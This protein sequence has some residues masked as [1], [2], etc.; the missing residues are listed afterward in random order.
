[1]DRIFRKRTVSGSRLGRNKTAKNKTPPVAPLPQLPPSLD[2]DIRSSLI[3]PGLTERFSVLLPSLAAAP[4]TSVR[5]LLAQQRNRPN[6]PSLTLEE[7]EMLFAEMQGQSTAGGHGLHAPR[8]TESRASALTTDTW[9]GNPPPLEGDWGSLV[10]RGAGAISG[11]LS[12]PT[13]RE[14]S[15]SR[16]G[17][18]PS[19][20]DRQLSPSTSDRSLGSPPHSASYSS[21]NTFGPDEGRPVP[22]SYGFSGSQGWRDANYLRSVKKSANASKTSVATNGHGEYNPEASTSPRQ[23]PSTWSTSPKATTPKRKP[24]PEVF[25]LNDSTEDLHE[26]RDISQSPSSSTRTVTPTASVTGSVVP[27]P[28]RSAPTRAS[29]DEPQYTTTP[30]STDS[31]FSKPRPRVQQVGGAPQQRQSLLVGITPQQAKRISLALLEIEGHLGRDAGHSS[32]SSHD[33]NRHDDHEELLEGYEDEAEEGEQTVTLDRQRSFTSTSAASSV[34]PFSVSPASS[35]HGGAGSYQGSMAPRSPAGEPTSP[36]NVPSLPSSPQTTKDPHLDQHTPPPHNRHASPNRQRHY[37]SASIASTAFSG[38]D[39]DDGHLPHP[40]LTPYRPQPVRATPSPAFGMS[41]GGS[42]YVPGQPRPV[43]SVSSAGSTPTVGSPQSPYSP[44]QTTELP[45]RLQY[46]SPGSSATTLPQ[47]QTRTS[48][49]RAPSA[50]T[51]YSNGSVSKIDHVPAPGV[52]ASRHATGHSISE[53]LSHWRSGSALNIHSPPMSRVLS[54]ADEARSS[55]ASADSHRSSTAPTHSRSHSADPGFRS[56]LVTAGV[57]AGG[58]GAA[59]AGAASL[60]HARGPSLGLAPNRSLRRAASYDS[61]SSDYKITPTDEAKSG[62]E[63]IVHEHHQSQENLLLLSTGEEEHD[64]EYL[65]QVSGVGKDDLFAMQD[66]LMERAKAERERQRALHALPASPEVGVAQPPSVASPPAAISRALETEVPQQQDYVQSVPFPAQGSQVSLI[67]ATPATS[68]PFPKTPSQTTLVAANK[69]SPPRERGPPTAWKTAG[70]APVNAAAASSSTVHLPVDTVAS[71][72][73]PLDPKFPTEHVPASE[74]PKGP[75]PPRPQHPAEAPVLPVTP[76]TPDAVATKADEEE[77]ARHDVEMRIKQAN[78]E[79]FR[80]PSRIAHKRSLSKKKISTPTLVSTSHNQ[81]TTPITPAKTEDKERH[82]G[83]KMSMRW[84]KLVHKKSSISGADS[85]QTAPPVVATPPSNHKKTKSPDIHPTTP[86]SPKAAKQP[87]PPVPPM[88]KSPPEPV[89]PNPTPRSDINSFKFPYSGPANGVN[90]TH[91][92]KTNGRADMGAQPPWGAQSKAQSPPLKSSLKVTNNDAPRGAHTPTA[93]DSSVAES[94]HKFMEAGRA[95]GLDDDRLNDVLVQN[96]ILDRTATSN[97]SRSYQSTAPTTTTFSESSRSPVSPTVPTNAFS[98]WAPSKKGQHKAKAPSRDDLH[99]VPEVIVQ[100]EPGVLRRTLVVPSDS[101]R[102]PEPQ[103]TPNANHQALPPSPQ[104]A[105]YSLKGPSSPGQ[106]TGSF[107]SVGRQNSI[108]RKPVQRSGVEERELVNRSPVSSL[109]TRDRKVSSFSV[110]DSEVSE[111]LAPPSRQWNG[112][113]DSP[114]RQFFGG[115]DSA[116]AS[117]DSSRGGGSIYDYYGGN[118]G[119]DRGSQAVEITEYAD[120]RVVWNIVN[121]LRGDRGSTAEQS[122]HDNQRESLVS[123]SRQSSE[124]NERDS[125]AQYGETTGWSVG[126]TAGLAFPRRPET[127]VYYTYSADVADLIDQLS[128]DQFAGAARG[129]ID[130]RP[131]GLPSDNRAGIGAGGAGFDPAQFADAPSPI[132]PVT[133][134]RQPIVSSPLTPNKGR[135]FGSEAHN[136]FNAGLSGA[137]GPAD[138][139]S[140]SAASFHSSSE[141]GRPERSVEDRLQALMD[142]LRSAPGGIAPR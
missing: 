79:L 57:V 95:V 9:D 137:A 100:E 31:A 27:G 48:V 102:T 47:T 73:S 81:P 30:L 8:V 126:P 103:A 49:A 15:T 37:H 22:R 105:N 86:P 113:P 134:S 1:M 58:A 36:P 115:G 2:V 76:T 124:V 28:S 16:S 125:V 131:S 35:N 65:K 93:S 23:T 129:R 114:R 40:A 104:D 41:G 56:A 96:S 117:L 94:I 138:V 106:S 99:A 67:S 108:R 63:P 44:A 68:P 123:S 132:P 92:P 110:T 39:R 32:Q 14:R 34:F 97:S 82:L 19:T 77:D 101:D 13:L 62:W 121:A 43:R 59:A 46:A 3:L 87:K 84:K 120:G 116:R 55:Y 109:D 70:G 107:S 12:S 4:K 64:A 29:L 42:T 33:Y 98:E 71:T 128:S 18:S 69:A 38:D 88:P 91:P 53:S 66:R 112:I 72:P 90:G 142:R 24:L 139:Q 60:A 89:K 51:H 61:F 7:E 6:G 26:P 122:F 21:F 130:I 17:L 119:G 80:A 75:P 54:E 118:D 133:N 141:S 20:S 74:L 111:V 45:R 10:D 11:S 85:I 52:L 5:T 140:P 78:A 136:R 50:A 135:F 25:S 127:R 83:R